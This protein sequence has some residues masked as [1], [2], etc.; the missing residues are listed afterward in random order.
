[1][2]FLEYLVERNHKIFI[3]T[4]NCFIKTNDRSAVEYYSKCDY[5]DAIL[6]H[7]GCPWVFT[8]KENEAAILE[9]I[10]NLGKARIEFYS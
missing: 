7:I 8:T 10:E 1:M 6:G 9:E 4:T 3:N 2:E 5:N